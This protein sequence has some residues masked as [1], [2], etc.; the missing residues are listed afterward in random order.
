MII[1]GAGFA[2]AALAAALARRG[3]RPLLLDQRPLPRSGACGELLPPGA[4]RS[5]AALG[6]LSAAAQADP[7]PVSAVDLI[8]PSGQELR[9]ELPGTALGVRRAALDQALTDEARSAGAEVRVGA[10]VRAVTPCPGGFC[11]AVGGERL[12][13]RLV[14]GAW[15]GHPP[16]TRLSRRHAWVGVK[17]LYAGIAPG[18]EA[19]IYPVPG[20]CVGLVGAGCCVSFSAVAT[21]PAFRRS[22]GSVER[23]VAWAAE[24]NPALA[25][26]LA[27][28]TPLGGCEV[29]IAAGTGLPPGA[30]CAT[31]LRPPRGG[32]ATRAPLLAADG[33]T[34]IAPLAAG[35][36]VALRSAEALLPLLERHLTGELSVTDLAAACAA[37]QAREVAVPLR[38]AR[39]LLHALVS[40][41]GAELLFTLGR[42][43]PGWIRRGMLAERGPAAPAALGPSVP[44]MPPT[45]S[46]TAR[47]EHM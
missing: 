35:T 17:R 40:P 2:G 7:W 45:P 42:V 32:C 46:G 28:G 20:G 10:P 14:V 37:Q 21:L 47:R 31:L 36:A 29:T 15:G 8:A 33:G 30:D 18:P 13:A 1:A 41:S 19:E 43:W 26:R 11:V 34:A 6:L 25:R 44:P 24:Q 3:W 5:L 4:L 12:V 38:L 27:P 22:G 23:F 16:G 9:L 39:W